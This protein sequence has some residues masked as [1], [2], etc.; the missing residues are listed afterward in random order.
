MIRRASHINYAT[1]PSRCASRWRFVCLLGLLC[2]LSTVVKAQSQ[3]VD[4]AYQA[5][6]AGNVYVDPNL[7]DVDQAKLQAASIAGPLNDGNPHTVVKIVVLKTLPQPYY[8]RDLYAHQLGNSLGIGKNALIVVVAK[9]PGRGVSI[10]TDAN[11]SKPDRDAMAHQVWPTITT[12]STETAGIAE[13]AQMV[14]AKINVN[15]YNGGGGT[16]LWVIFLA[17]IVV[18][19]FLIAS[20]SRNRK[21]EME[22]RRGPIE[23]LRGNVL[24][25]IEYLDNYIDVL[26]KN[27]PDS[28]QVRI[29][30]QAASTKFDQAVKI[31]SRAT[32]MS[33]LGRAQGLLDRAQADV[34]QG[35]RYL[36]RATGGTGSIPGDDAFRPE[37]LPESQS[38]VSAIP[39]NRRGV[40][41]F[42]G[43]PASIGSLV[44]VTIT[45]NGMSRQ[46]LVTPDEAD[47]MRQGR[48]PQVRAFRVGG[49]YV[50]WY[51][52]PDYDPYRDYWAYENAGWGGFG[53]GLV[54]GFVG[55]EILDSLVAPM[56]MPYAFATD[57]AYY[58]DAMMSGGYDQMG[59]GYD[60]GGGLGGDYGAGNFGGDTSPYDDT[61]G[62]NF[63]DSGGSGDFGNNDYGGGY[64]SGGGDFGGGD[65]GGGDSGGGGGDF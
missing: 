3:T 38:A 40:S 46:V 29:Y 55:A 54:A 32:E 16:M 62:V 13:L 26:P 61:S 4:P 48:M 47:E 52:Y 37:P 31:L 59:G 63:P 12:A 5:L 1:A 45:V 10:E 24:T 43:Q 44:P 14:S 49:G 21:R 25:G 11:L 2:C 8:D 6:L 19:G 17:V 42:S 27:N 28:D 9:N 15:E 18:I 41:F 58:N 23:A 33:D 36:D 20:A 56:A 65:S 57:S 53:S 51:A 35:R 30:R 34:E 64:D 22:A 7:R 60:P 50:P 39:Q